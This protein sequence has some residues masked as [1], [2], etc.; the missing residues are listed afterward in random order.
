MKQTTKKRISK[1][2][3]YKKVF[4]S[5]EGSKVLQDLMVNCNM[6]SNMCTRSPIDPLDLAYKEGQRSVCLHIL[7]LVKEDISAIE[8]RIADE[9]RLREDDY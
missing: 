1:S 9:E 3:L 7:K 4:G 8:K 5:D 2:Y 6:M